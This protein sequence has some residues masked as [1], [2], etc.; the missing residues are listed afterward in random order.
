MTASTEGFELDIH[1]A[2]S[3]FAI[4]YEKKGVPWFERSWG[5]LLYSFDSFLSFGWSTMGE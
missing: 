2:F 1:D 5:P 3:S 4:Y